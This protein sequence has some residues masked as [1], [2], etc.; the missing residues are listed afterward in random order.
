MKSMIGA[1]FTPVMTSTA[2]RF[3]SF[4]FARVPRNPV[5]A[6]V[7]VD[8]IRQTVVYRDLAA[9]EQYNRK[10]HK[11]VKDYV[12]T[13]SWL[14]NSKTTVCLKAKDQRGPQKLCPG[15][16]FGARLRNLPS[17]FLL[18]NRTAGY[19]G[20]F[21]PHFRAFAPCSQLQLSTGATV[22]PQGGCA[23]SFEGDAH[24]KKLCTLFLAFLP[25]IPLFPQAAVSSQDQLAAHSRLAQQYLNERRPDLAIPEF[26]ALVKLAPGN[27]DAQANLG[28]L[29]FFQGDYVKAEPH[30]RVAL[31]MQPSLTKIQALLGMAEKRTGETA[32]ARMHLEASFAAV[33]E[34]KLKVQI[35]MELVELYTAS[36]DL[37][38]ASSVVN[39][40]RQSDP[41]NPAVLYAAYRIYSDLTGEAMLSLA[42]AAP[43]SAQMHQ[44]MAHEEARQGNTA[45]ARVQFEKAL[46]IDPKLPGIHF[47]LGELLGISED[48][49]TKA[50][51]ESEYKAAI[52]ENALDE[53]AERRLGDL[54]SQKGD[55][56]Q[57]LQHYN[58]AL[59]LQPDDA[60]AN[61]GL[62]K[63]LIAMNEQAKALPILERA[64]Q[65]EPTNA[66]AH[67]RLSTIYREM[68][69]TADSQHE[70]EEYK[71]YKLMKEKLEAIFKEMQVRPAGLSSEEQ[72]SK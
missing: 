3:R 60:E 22:C 24:K 50:S 53:K 12:G 10:R 67:F 37:E 11:L 39:A 41:A 49:K 65:L 68:G 44:V 38:K 25:T 45:G 36:Q 56:A 27:L 59:R 32:N 26:E 33:T 14:G 28:V 54:S 17:F 52:A 70:V 42:L 20:I 35:G 71:S 19:R 16:A 6:L 7:A 63:T 2:G 5:G 72:E 4:F 46:Q 40:M 48:A 15:S 57:A 21:V 31:E 47:E 43:D 13:L 30:L 23:V 66:A 61:F 9:R 34:P 64:V 69:R 62:A 8:S 51:A 58:T 29:L 18:R 1:F 55:S